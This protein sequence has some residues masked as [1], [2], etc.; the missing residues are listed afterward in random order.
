MQKIMIIEDDM[1][2]ASTL[3][4]H[5]EKWNYDVLVE[6]DF[7]HILEHF[8]E[9][10]PHLVLL[11]ISLPFYDG[12]HWCQKMREV[13]DVP[14]IFIS[15]AN[16]NMNIVMAMNMGGDD[17]IAKPFDL[18]VLT[19]KIQAI[20]RRT[21]S[22]SKDFHILSYK[23]M[24]LNLV[25]ASLSYQQQTIELTK[26]ELKILQ[27]LFEK[28]ETIICREDIMNHLWQSHQFIDDNTLSV[29]V[30]RLR[31]KMEDIGLKDVIITKKGLGYMLCCSNI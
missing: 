22:F 19:A 6:K 1:I 26:N 4:Q 9:Y 23:E 13:S 31:K 8:V 5:L 11:D 29:N 27:L 14:I 17:F 20:L 18:V 2:I 3:K 10:N 24:M 21:Y 28:P 16:E 15:S 7:E 25:D 30:N 12:Y